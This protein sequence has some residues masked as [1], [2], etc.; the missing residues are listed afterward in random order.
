MRSLH[1]IFSCR[2]FSFF[3]IMDIVLIYL[4][5]RSKIVSVFK[6][7]KCSRPAR[8]VDLYFEILSHVDCSSCLTCCND[9]WVNRPIKSIRTVKYIY[10]TQKYVK[11]RFL[12]HFNLVRKCFVFFVSD[13]LYLLSSF[14]SSTK[15][16]V[17]LALAGDDRKYN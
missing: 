17:E 11:I 10:I 7:R 15:S 3:F 13:L 14:R 5:R 6:N 12:N 9:N 2:L 1:S 16:K 8:P 4:N